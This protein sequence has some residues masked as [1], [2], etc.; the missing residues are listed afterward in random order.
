VNLN[1]SMP[2]TLACG[3]TGSDWFT[4]TIVEGYF[5]AARGC[6]DRAQPPSPAPPRPRTAQA[7]ATVATLANKVDPNGDALRAAITQ[8]NPGSTTLGLDSVV[9]TGR[10]HRPVRHGS[11]HPCSADRLNEWLKG[12]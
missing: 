2:W 6:G 1:Q 9:T 12:L 10:P 8:P 5:G 4:Y 7:A 11:L 3:G